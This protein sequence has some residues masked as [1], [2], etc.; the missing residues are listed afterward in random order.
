MS[1][2]PAW[3]TLG[4]RAERA[5]IGRRLGRAPAAE[6]GRARRQRLESL[7]EFERAW[8]SLDGVLR[9]ALAQGPDDRL[10]ERY[11]RARPALLRSYPA[12]KPVL[13]AY[14]PTEPPRHRFGSPPDDFERL[15]HPTTLARVLAGDRAP[16]VETLERMRAAV[17]LYRRH[18]SA[19]LGQP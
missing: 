2:F 9:D 12:L 5:W 15:F 8:E 4:R 6:A 10:E 19:L 13:G 3:P 16:T 7:R 17:A 11:R 1:L 18:L 14:L